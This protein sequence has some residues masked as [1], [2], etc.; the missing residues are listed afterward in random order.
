MPTLRCSSVGSCIAWITFAFM[1]F[2]L[3]AKEQARPPQSLYSGLAWRM[4]G[5]YRGGRVNA[6]S[7]VPGQPNTFYFGSVGG[8]LWKSTNSGRTWWPVFDSQS[9]ASIG[10]IGVSPSNPEIV[11]VGTGECDMRDSIAF[12]DGMYK[13]SDGGRTWRHIGLEATRQIGRVLVNPR[14]PDIVFVAALGHA[15]GPNSDRG[16]YR[17]RDGGASWQKVLYK[18]DSVGAID[19]AFDPSD[20]QTIYAALWATRRPPWYIYNPSNGPGSGIFKSTDGGTTWQALTAG[21][22]TE[23]VGRIGI[24]VAPSNAKR[25]YAIVDAREGGLYR[26]EDSGATWTRISGDSRVWGRGWYFGKVTVDPKDSDTVYV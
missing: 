3:P 11:Y 7:G 22:P 10:A 5:P 25:V 17:S 13:S 9:V 24:A 18:N 16:V 1:V 4:V 20:V 15:Y 23:G 6:V 8:G 21:L 2:L 14:N 19:L 12:G 26:S